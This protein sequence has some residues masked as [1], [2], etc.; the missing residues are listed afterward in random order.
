V[1]IR[2][3]EEFAMDELVAPSQCNFLFDRVFL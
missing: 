2:R 3:V 1:V